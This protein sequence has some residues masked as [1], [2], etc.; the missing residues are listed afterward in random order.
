MKIPFIQKV[1]PKF[2]AHFQEKWGLCESFKGNFTR[3]HL[4]WGN[5]EHPISP[6]D[7]KAQRNFL[8]EGDWKRLATFPLK[9]PMI[10]MEE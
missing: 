1:W 8:P 2:R 3:S 9:H 5:L 6:K 4:N 10:T 7:R